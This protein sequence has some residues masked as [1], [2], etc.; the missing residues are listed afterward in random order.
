MT[1][2]EYVNSL[3]EVPEYSVL[4][5]MIGDTIVEL[6]IDEITVAQADIPK[7]IDGRQVK[8]FIAK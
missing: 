6:F 8:I 4:G 3:M 1:I 2:D 7:F 5:F